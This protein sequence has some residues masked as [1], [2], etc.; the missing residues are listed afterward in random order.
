MKRGKRGDVASAEVLR[1]GALAKALAEHGAL[2]DAAARVATKSTAELA[3]DLSTIRLEL[4]G[5]GFADV[6]ELLMCIEG[7]ITGEPPS[8]R[9]VAAAVKATRPRGVGKPTSMAVRLRRVLVR[10]VSRQRAAGHA[11]AVIAENVVSSIVNVL[12]FRRPNVDVATLP[13][14]DA[15]RFVNN[16]FRAFPEA[17][18]VDNLK[19]AEHGE[20]GLKKR[21]RAV[22][23]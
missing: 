5:R 7:A 19:S 2:L 11:D 16:C 3:I 18:R 14:A 1:A 12:R 9:A 21:R 8:E 10:E 4:N 15:E 20:R 17:G 6:A 13:H 23:S 22:R